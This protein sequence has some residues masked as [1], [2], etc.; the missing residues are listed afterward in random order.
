MKKDRN[1]VKLGLLCFYLFVYKFQNDIINPAIL[2]SCHAAIDNFDISGLY[3]VPAPF[4]PSMGTTI[5][6]GG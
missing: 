5:K 4:S 1:I 2:L 3:E 6:L